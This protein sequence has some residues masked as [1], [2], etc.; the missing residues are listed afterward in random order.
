M[1]RVIRL[2]ELIIAVMFIAI[3]P[4]AGAQT[5]PGVWNVPCR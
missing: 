1:K 5:D 4:Y 3:S 2:S